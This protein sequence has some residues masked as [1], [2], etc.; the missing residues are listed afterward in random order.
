MDKKKMMRL[1]SLSEVTTHLTQN[2]LQSLIE[3]S[4]VKLRLLIYTKEV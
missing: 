2:W 4:I 3:N 1:S